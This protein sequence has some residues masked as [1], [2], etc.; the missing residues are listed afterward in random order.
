[1]ITPFTFLYLKFC[2]EKSFLEIAANLEKYEKI[3]QLCENKLIF[4]HDFLASSFNANASFPKIVIVNSIWAKELINNM[5]S[6]KTVNAFMIT[7]GHEIGHKKKHI[8]RLFH[9]CN[10]KFLS[11]IQEVYCDFYSAMVME[12]SNRQKLLDAIEYKM[13]HKN[14]KGEDSSHPS[15][16]WRLEYSASYNFDAELIRKIYK[17]SE[18]EN[19]ELLDKVIEFYKGRHII[20]KQTPSGVCFF[21]SDILKIKGKVFMIALNIV[22][23]FGFIICLFIT[24]LAVL[25]YFDFRP[26]GNTDPFPVKWIIFAV[27]FGILLYILD[28]VVF[29]TIIT[30]AFYLSVIS[31]AYLSIYFLRY[32]IGNLLYIVGL[33]LM[34]F[35]E[36]HSMSYFLKRYIVIV[37]FTIGLFLLSK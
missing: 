36:Y 21:T 33:N 9:L 24:Y 32:A 30:I 31:T 15:W 2:S 5:D 27:M 4:F 3:P 14:I 1:M 11:W 23:V 19:Q 13:K 17:D 6:T 16:K 29:S 35:E 37:L 18:C 7:I 8:N 26:I 12:N 28:E 22:F 20:L 34:N 10:L 25:F